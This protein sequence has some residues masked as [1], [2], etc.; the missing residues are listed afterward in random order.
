MERLG[1]SIDAEALIGLIQALPN[2]QILFMLHNFLHSPANYD[3]CYIASL[4]TGT[5]QPFVTRR[6]KQCGTQTVPDRLQNI[7]ALILLR[8]SV[9]VV[10][11][12]RLLQLL[13]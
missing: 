9:A 1:H 7:A 3:A 5:T 6:N 4:L 10:S 2:N 12:L 13:N 11:F 8:E